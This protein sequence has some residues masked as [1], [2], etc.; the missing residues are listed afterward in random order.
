MISVKENGINIFFNDEQ[1]LKHPNPIDFIFERNE[2]F[3]RDSHCWKTRFPIE[4]T[5]DGIIICFNEKHPLNARVLM[6]V[7]DEGSSKI[8]SSN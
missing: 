4:S 2:T 3:V 1:H 6:T 7:N 8:T 5:E